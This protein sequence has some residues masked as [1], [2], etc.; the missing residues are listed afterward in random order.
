[1]RIRTK[2]TLL[3]SCIGFLFILEVSAYFMHSRQRFAALFRN[4][5]AEEKRSFNKLLASKSE[6]LNAFSYDY[7]YWDDMVNFIKT[8]DEAWARQNILS[9]LPTFKAD[10]AWVYG[11]D[12]S[13]VYSTDT[14]SNARLPLEDEAFPKIFS[15]TKHFCHFFINTESGLLEVSGASVHPTADTK[16]ESSAQGYF[17]AGQ[18]WGKEFVQELQELTSTTLKISLLQNEE[19]TPMPRFNPKEGTIHFFQIL[20]GWNNKPLARLDVWFESETIKLAWK[21]SAETFL[22]HLV[23]VVLLLSIT[24]VFIVRWVSA[25]LG[26][27]QST[28]ATGDV[29][30][31]A[32]FVKGRDEYAQLARLILES[33]RQK[34]ILSKE[35]VERKKMEDERETLLKWQKDITLLQQSLLVSAPLENKLKTITDSIVRIFDADFCRIWLIRPGDLCEQGCMHAEV[36]EGPHVCR[37]RTKCLHLMSSSGRYTHIDGK[38]HVRVPFGCYKIGHVASGKDHRFVTNDVV[39]DPRVHNH[40]WARELGLVSFAGYQLRIP[41]EET[42]GVLALFAKH[43]ISPAGDTALDS[44]STTTAFVVQQAVAEDNLGRQTEK[45]DVALKDSL[46]SR[47]IL[48]SMLEDNNRIRETLEG[49]LQEL[50]QAQ[51]MLVQSEKLASL[52]RLVS[53]MAHEVNNPLMIISG[54]AQLSLL[55]ES[56]NEELKNNLKIIHEECNRAKSIIQRLLMFSRPSKGE[57]KPLDI[58]QS[59]E[60]V[61]KLLEHQFSLSNVKINIQF[62]TGLPII[63]AD[64]KQLQEVIMNLLNNAR[65][66]MSEGGEITINT[67]LDG[68]YLK[69]NIKD[70]GVGMDDKTLT[71]V[72]EPF[73]TTK[74]KGTGLGLSVCYGIIK[75]HGGKIEVKSQPQ[76]GTNVHIWLPLKAEGV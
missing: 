16:R 71:R 29:S 6:F 8:K 33:V 24:A 10:M 3:L 66:A 18:L 42:I 50:K 1:M 67:S 12:F 61:V 47:D 25:P 37:L 60:S 43:P 44:L 57:S 2:I 65:D 56:L 30:Y 53:D 9:A 19:E 13:L 45:L 27:L 52:G 64:E 15:G 51:S 7:S 14:S 20:N 34:E 32:D 70:S 58:N 73:F 62:N 22:G 40:E 36:R 54:N 28:L 72:F 38:G 59:I 49:K 55:D 26:S 5:A 17:F 21:A 23:F 35:V 69:I 48:A 41:G 31:L 63:A 4:E 39:N 11:Q 46:K 68:E 75:A 74:E 76:K